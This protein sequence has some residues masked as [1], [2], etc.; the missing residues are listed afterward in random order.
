MPDRRTA[1]KQFLFISA[2]AA[3]IPSCM[4]DTGKASV[5]L[6]N[7]SINGDEEKMLAEVAETIIPK[8]DTPGAKDISAHLFALK[9]IDDCTSRED[10]QKF[11][12]G[13]KAFADN[14]KKKN[15][16]SF[17]E[18]DAAQKDALIADLDKIK[19]GKDDVSFFYGTMK[20]Y[21]VQAYTTSKFYMTTVHVYKMLPGKFQGCVP[22]KTA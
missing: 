22:V 13:M 12:S 10:Q 9:M 8:T 21:T 14:A 1:I 15:G 11:L 5:I 6:K 16:K 19:D 3:I 2:G 20:R 7:I 4:Q 17:I 18:S